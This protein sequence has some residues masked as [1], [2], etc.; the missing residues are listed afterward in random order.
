MHHSCGAYDNP[1][2]YVKIANYN[3]VVLLGDKECK[4]MCTPDCTHICDVTCDVI[5]IKNETC[6]EGRYPEGNPCLSCMKQCRKY[7]RAKKKCGRVDPHTCRPG[8]GKF[9]DFDM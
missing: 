9:M 3:K 1:I 5:C 2:D 4:E 7:R 8:I 6:E